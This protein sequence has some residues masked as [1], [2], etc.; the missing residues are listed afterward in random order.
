[1]TMPT[2]PLIIFD[3]DHHMYVLPDRASAE[4]YWEMPDEFVC[5]FDSQARPLRMS[6]APHQVSID[7]GSAEP[8]EAELRR[9]VADHYQRFLPTHVPPRASDLAR[10]VAELPA[11]VT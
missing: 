8:A 3:D 6:G 11:T 10:F 1:M 4:A 9:R 2:G 5:G 7:V